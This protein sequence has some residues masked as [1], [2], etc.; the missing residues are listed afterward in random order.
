MINS[1]DMQVS[2]AGAFG[3]IA[4][5][6]SVRRLPASKRLSILAALLVAALLC[7]FIS[8]DAQAQVK[9]RVVIVDTVERQATKLFG[10]AVEHAC[11]ACGQIE[12]RHIAG[13]LRTGRLVAEELR[14][15]QEKGQIDLIITLGKPATNIMAGRVKNTPIFYT[16]VGAP[17][18]RY[19]DSR[20]VR[21]FP[22]DAPISLQLDVLR[23]L[24]PSVQRIGIVTSQEKAQLLQVR[25]EILTGLTIYEIDQQK[26][27][28]KALRRAV[29][30][31][32]ALIFLRDPVVINNDSLKFILKITLAN[33][34]HTVGYSSALVDRGLAFALVP[35]P[36]AFGARVGVAAQRHLTGQEAGQSVVSGADYSIHRN[37]TVLMQAMTPQTARTSPPEASR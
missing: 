21:G 33:R 29:A 26:H 27:M 23:G 14:S 18:A 22:T 24:A 19:V 30:A 16:M 15:A 13:S 31:N 5:G 35:K 36:A 1:Y 9:G 4:Q 17:I 20:N 37:E 7:L 6:T 8:E 11:S 34:I 28:P 12:Y 25:S 10:A 3:A 32:D 2:V